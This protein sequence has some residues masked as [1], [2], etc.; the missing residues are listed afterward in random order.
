M[1]ITGL[2]GQSGAGKTFVGKEL[3]KAGFIIINADSIAGE[4]MQRDSPCLRE[5]VSY[6]GAEILNDDKTLDRKKLADI[7][8]SDSDKLHAL[9]EISYKYINMKVTALLEKYRENGEK[10]VI[11]DAPTLFEA[12]EDKMCGVIV[13]VVA[14]ENI[15][16]RRIMKR[17]KISEESARK[18]FA[19]QHTEEFF[20][21]NSDIII[22]NNSTEYELK[23]QIK[24]TAEKLLK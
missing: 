8:F 20:R 4:V 24:E 11:I 3:E 9:N 10:Y 22:E 12:G 15:R 6:F 5:T 16:L 14:D 13:S 1:K 19:S 17:D 23:N 18:R 21:E 2:T 7:V